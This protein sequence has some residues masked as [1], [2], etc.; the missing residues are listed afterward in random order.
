MLEL[1][2]AG[3]V[4]TI[5]NDF[6]PTLPSY[7]DEHVLLVLL[8]SGIALCNASWSQISAPYKMSMEVVFLKGH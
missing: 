3:K 7:G 2:E 1:G 5:A 4:K 8:E 6:C